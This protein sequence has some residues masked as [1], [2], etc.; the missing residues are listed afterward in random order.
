MNELIHTLPFR[1]SN[2]IQV[3][4]RPT[5]AQSHTTDAHYKIGRPRFF[6]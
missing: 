3:M 1:I 4:R 6:L 2:H 5:Y